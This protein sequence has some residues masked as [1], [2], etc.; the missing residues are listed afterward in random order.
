MTCKGDG[1]CG[2]LRWVTV[3]LPTDKK[4]LGFT[5]PLVCS[6]VV[7]C[8]WGYLWHNLVLSSHVPFFYTH[9]Y[10]ALL[11]T[12]ENPFVQSLKTLVYC[13]QFNVIFWPFCMEVPNSVYLCLFMRNP[14]FW[15]WTGDWIMPF[16]QSAPGRKV[17][18][19][20]I[21]E[22]SSHWAVRQ[23]WACERKASLEVRSHFNCVWSCARTLGI[24]MVLKPGLFEYSRDNSVTI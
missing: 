2:C 14:G 4:K 10:C 7:V 5:L 21:P 6:G 17:T 23:Q 20:M 16:C 8:L 3:L 1:C 13:T 19:V 15:A 22:L 18:W 9:L 24:W 11:M 12:D